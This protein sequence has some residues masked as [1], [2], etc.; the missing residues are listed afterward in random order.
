M[1]FKE[2]AACLLE[3]HARLNIRNTARVQVFEADSD[4]STFV[5]AF[6]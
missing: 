6:P 5:P 2:G 3:E 1:Y 4:M